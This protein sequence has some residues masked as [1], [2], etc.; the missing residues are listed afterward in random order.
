VPGRDQSTLRRRRL[1]SPRV[2]LGIHART[3]ALA[4][5]GEPAGR[6]FNLVVKSHPDPIGYAGGDNLYAYAGNDPATY[7]DPFGLCPMCIGA[8]AGAILGGGG[9]AIYNYL[10]GAPL[11]EGVLASAAIGAVAG[12]TLGFGYGALA[13]RGTAAAAQLSLSAPAGAKLGQMIARWHSDLGGQG[14]RDAF[15]NFATNFVQQAQRA[16][17]A[18]T[19]AV[20]RMQNAQIFRV[21]NNYLLVDAAGKLRSFV[22]NARAGE[23][24]VKVYEALGGR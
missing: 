12:G 7:T 4:R 1:C 15:M 23:G 2:P 11:G 6:Y 24:I 8:A 9:H 22:T 14:G 21:D 19:G 17:Q 18:V 3:G 16:G 10:T 13:A 20:G 5:R